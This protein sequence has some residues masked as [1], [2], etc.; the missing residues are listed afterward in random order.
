MGMSELGFLFWGVLKFTLSG[1]FL[2]KKILGSIFFLVKFVRMSTTTPVTLC[3]NTSLNVTIH[4]PESAALP[5]LKV[6][7]QMFPKL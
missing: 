1:C 2:G 4:L 3:W 7:Q 5:P 6:F